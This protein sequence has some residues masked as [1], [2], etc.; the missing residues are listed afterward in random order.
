MHSIAD[1]D[2]ILQ[3]GGEGRRIGALDGFAPKPMLTVGGTPM[4]ER[5]LSQLVDLGFRKFTVVTGF[6]GAVIEERLATFPASL[7]CDIELGFFHEIA[8][9]GNAGALGAIQSVDRTVLFTF[10]DL[11][12]QIDFRIL[13]ATHWE[14]QCD[15][16]LASHLEEHQLSLGELQVDG[17]RVTDYREKP[18][19]QFL[20][21]S[22]IAAFEPSVVQIARR[23]PT[24]FG[25]ADLIRSALNQ[26][27]N[28]MHWTHKSLWMDVNTPEL[29][30]KARGTVASEQVYCGGAGSLR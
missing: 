11:V 5:L 12:T 29:L 3:A 9:L 7:S 4:V 25:L 30:Q 17:E 18:K 16:T 14:R 2:V 6:K 19:K 10:A 22:G 8:P 27:C 28:V 20:I 24:P 13:L 23:L 1:I 15:A 26:R 21:C